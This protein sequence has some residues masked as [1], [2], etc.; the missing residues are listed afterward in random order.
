MRW[1]FILAVVLAAVS[2]PALAHRE[3]S[4]RVSPAISTI[5]G[6]ATV[7]D[8]DTIDIDGT[9]I[10]LHGIDAPESRQTCVAAGDVW[11]C[12]HQATL[13]LADFIGG[14]PVRCR[15]LDMDRYGR[16]VAAC[17][18]RGDDVEAWMVLSGWA[19]AYRQYSPDYVG[20][21]Q[22]AQ[23]AR[24]GVWRGEF[25][26]PWDWRK[27]VRLQAA[28][29]TDS[30]VGCAI[31][32][33]ISSK[34]ERIYHVPGGQYYERTKINTVKGERWFCTEVEAVAA[35]WRKAKR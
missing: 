9:R 4:H 20:E 8:G 13:A 17:S 24:V 5:T 34:G 14:S 16:I 10:R 28:T 11:R 21:E 35:G 22:A 6:T 32:G 19:L 1:P 27:G 26:P 25:V 2:A 12:G 30:A 3:G 15:K 33:N 29:V 18:V 23:A 31:K 7:I